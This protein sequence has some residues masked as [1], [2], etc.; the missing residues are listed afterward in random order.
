MASWAIGLGS[1][2]VSDTAS[3]QHNFNLNQEYHIFS[4]S[5]TFPILYRHNFILLELNKPVILTFGIILNFDSTLPTKS[6]HHNWQ[7]GALLYFSRFHCHFLHVFFTYPEFESIRTPRKT[8]P[9]DFSDTISRSGRACSTSTG[10]TDP[11]FGLSS[12][13]CEAIF[14]FCNTADIASFFHGSGLAICVLREWTIYVPI[15]FHTLSCIQ[16][17]RNNENKGKAVCIPRKYTERM[18][19]CIAFSQ[20]Y[21]RTKM[22]NW[23]VFH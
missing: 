18:R 10:K 7:P 9:P 20:V 4:I 14:G 22:S 23:T 19:K 3:Q 16:T 17:Q 8:L 11:I 13:N 2:C 6:H 1:N 21:I 15:R 5:F 12:S